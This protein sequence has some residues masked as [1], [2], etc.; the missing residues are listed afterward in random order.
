MKLQKI[1]MHKGTK[2]T[3]GKNSETK[4]SYFLS[5]NILYL[6]SIS[7]NVYLGRYKMRTKNSYFFYLKDFIFQKYICK[8]YI[9]AK[10]ENI[11]KIEPG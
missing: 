5:K 7:V 6:I 4:Y 1:K 2:T 3:F 10:K 8:M 11:S 9:L